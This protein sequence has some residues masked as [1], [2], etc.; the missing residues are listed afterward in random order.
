MVK[1]KKDGP[2]PIDRHVGGLIKVR[3]TGLGISQTDLGRAIG[4]TFQQV[5]KYEKG[6]NRIGASNLYKI[7][8][9]LGVGVE[10][11]FQGLEND[12]VNPT[13]GSMSEGRQAP[14]DGDPLASRE[15]INLVH[16]YH[17]I[18]EDKVRRQIYQ[19]VKSLS[20]N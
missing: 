4:V 8:S 13:K 1:H 3:R 10:Y 7:A 14:F 19:L 18:P 20:E 11:F 9:T 15:A 6:A 17:R 2:D 16:A 5:Q 12:G